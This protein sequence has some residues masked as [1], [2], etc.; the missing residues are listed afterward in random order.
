MRISGFASGLDIDAMVKELMKAQRAP[1]DKLSQQRTVV[2]WQQEQYRD[3]N[4]KMVDFRNNKLF[5]YGMSDQISAKQVNVT[6]N[7]NAVS[8][9]A[10]SGATTGSM[11]IEVTKLASA[12][13][14]TSGP[15]T[16][17]VDTNLSLSA[18]KAAGAVNY[19]S[20]DQSITIN[21]NKITFDENTDTLASLVKKINSNSGANVNA[22]LDSTTGKMS[23]TSKT[24]GAA[25]TVAVSGDVLGR[26]NLT[27]SKAGADAEVKING[28]ETTRSSNTFTEN[29]VAITLNAVS[30]GAATT[31]NVTGNTDKTLETIKSFIAD[32]NSLLDTVNGK[33]NEQRYLKYQPLTDEQRTGMSDDEIK[34]WE[35]KAKSGLLYND[36]TLSQAISSMRLS[37]ITDVV[38]DG[39]NVNLTSLG[40]TT[41]DYTSRGKLVIQDENKLRAAIE[42]D[43]DKVMKFFAQQT[44]ETDS[45]K[46][47]SPT[48]PDNGLFNR[49]SNNIMAA[50]DGMYQK[51]GTSKLSTDANAAFSPTSLLGSQ[52]RDI[53]TRMSN[54]TDRLTDI[55]NNYYKQ[56]TAMETAMNRYNAQASS[57]F[58]ASQ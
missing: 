45:V 50:L 8:A 36:S 4:I 19:D 43:P 52:L 27:V 21:G 6:G 48:N 40:I 33:L 1:L 9:A 49:L 39:K 28:I 37:S 58:G 13:S 57:L 23:I 18:L 2:E 30:G 54:L 25:S 53:D 11:T 16:G 35:S 46:K 38:I 41:G 55:E 3:I 47:A 14:L 7:T 31:L 44:K 24:T 12:A 29:G 34:L 22:F 17:P 32:Y 26:F 15:G 20:A 42:A 5:S 56:F 51:A 10:V